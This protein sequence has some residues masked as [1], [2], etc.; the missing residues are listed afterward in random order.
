MTY[1]KKSDIFSET[2]TI[3]ATFG[4]DVSNL[5]LTE[6]SD[7]YLAVKMDVERQLYIDIK[8][9]VRELVSLKVTGLRFVLQSFLLISMVICQ[10]KNV[11][12]GMY[13][14]FSFN[15]YYILQPNIFNF[16]RC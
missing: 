9:S 8:Q 12:L 5:N 11:L 2:V 15:C 7:D 16:L 10:T 4:I 13:T 14:F 1:S 6:N 3:E